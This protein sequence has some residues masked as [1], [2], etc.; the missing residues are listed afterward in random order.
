MNFIEKEKKMDRRVA[1]TV[2]QIK[3]V[4]SKLLLKEDFNKITVKM[5]CDA[6]DIERKTFYLHFKD[7]HDLLS[8]VMEDHLELFRENV[9]KIPNAKPVDFYRA[10]L[11]VF[12]RHHETFKKV[13]NGQESALIWKKVQEYML[14]RLQIK[15]G[16]DIDPAIQYFIVAGIGG[17]F[18]AYVNGKLEGSKDQIAQDMAWMVAQAKEYLDKRKKLKK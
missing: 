10:A 7:K 2:R 13:Y 18:E 9:K 17:V 5:I 8:Q 1:R 6:A 12:D 14:H 15:Y 16:T 11:E 4:F 3:N